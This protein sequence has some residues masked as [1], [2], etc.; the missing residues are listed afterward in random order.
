MSFL[1]FRIVKQWDCTQSGRNRIR[2]HF[3]HIVGAPRKADDWII[4]DTEYSARRCLRCSSASHRSPNPS[5]TEAKKLLRLTFQVCASSKKYTLLLVWITYLWLERRGNDHQL[6]K[7]CQH[8]GATE[9]HFL[10]Q[11]K[12]VSLMNDQMFK[13]CRQR[14]QKNAH[15]RW[16]LQATKS[17]LCKSEQWIKVKYE[18]SP[19]NRS[20]CG[21]NEGILLQV[22]YVFF[23][24][25]DRQS[26]DMQ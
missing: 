5:S 12:N 13:I 18:Y 1:S 25:F 7:H 2:F 26:Y 9:L 24:S 16:K 14:L 6:Q 11:L 17:L 20:R 15:F 22:N 8:K 21:K 3:W 23:V 19:C 10:L 4:V